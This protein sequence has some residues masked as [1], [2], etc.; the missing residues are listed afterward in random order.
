MADRYDVVVIGAGPG[1]Y[2]AAIRCAQKGAKTAIIE[3]KTMGGTCLN[4][5]CI[6]SKALLA[7]AH[8]HTHA[9]HAA[10]KGLDL[11]G[12]F[13]PN[14]PKMVARKDAIVSGFTKGVTG[15]LQ[16]NKVAIF[17]GTGTVTAPGQVAVSG[18]A[19]AELEAKSIILATGSEPV[20]IPAFPFDYQ[21]IISST[22]ALS[23]PAIPPS[24][25]IIGGGVIGCEMA[26]I[27][28]SVG[29][30][31]TII[32]ALPQLLPNEDEW[33][34][35][36]LEKEFKKLGI[37]V[38]TGCKVLGVQVL[39]GGAVVQLESGQPV[40]CEKV[41]VAV[42]RRAFID[43]ET[44][45]NLNLQTKGS[46]IAVNEKMETSS[47][48]VYAIGDAVGTTYLAHGAFQEAEIAAANAVGGQHKMTAEDYAL[49]PRAVYSF[50]EVGSVG[51]NEK[52]CRQM[53]IELLIGKAPFRS[54]GR[55]VA[56]NENV[57]EIRVLRDKAT[58]K[59]VGVTMV[60]AQVTEMLAAA[61]A[62][63]G[64]AEP[65]EH[66]CFAHPTVSEVLKEAWEDAFGLSLHVPPMKK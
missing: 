48:G 66:V 13:T 65:I 3:K 38:K 60:G 47:P 61:R 32:E 59:I 56:H 46:V 10:L 36:L 53:G 51:Y 4:V 22:E 29:T 54:N 63:I 37:S 14:W 26:C 6:P 27:Y 42:G 20:N 18:P 39:A 12:S 34:A 43:K 52:K 23:L 1:G 19:P 44:V 33:V 49:I 50:P 15:L 28:A 57:G 64:S 7:S 30:Q 35:S 17:T 55:S 45:A 62:L 58:S 24:M 8:F 11:Q 40:A 41:L 16:A 2:A 5:G 25:V 21:S 31:V 9:K